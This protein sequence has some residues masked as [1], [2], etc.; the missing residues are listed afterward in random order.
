MLQMTYQLLTLAL[1]V[2]RPRAQEKLAK[3]LNWQMT[4][5][6]NN[7]LIYYFFETKDK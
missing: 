5:R 1:L 7:F 2:R 6:E 3:T 4:A